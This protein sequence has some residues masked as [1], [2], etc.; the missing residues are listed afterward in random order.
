LD[1]PFF[2]QL[3]SDQELAQA[4]VDKHQKKNKKEKKSKAQ[5]QLEKK[6][7]AELE[8]LLM[9]EKEELADGGH[10]NAKDIIKK[11]KASKSKKQRKAIKNLQLDTQESFQFDLTDSRFSALMDDHEFAVDPTNSQYTIFNQVSK[12]PALCVNY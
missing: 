3:D 8:L 12:I 5:K 9:D 10:F 1:D 4:P 2:Q 11:E 6:S 7:K